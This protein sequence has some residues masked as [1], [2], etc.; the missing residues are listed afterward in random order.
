MNRST[1]CA[2]GALLLA[3]WAGV[4]QAAERPRTGLVLSGGGAR[5]AAHIGVLRVL[6]RERVPIDC[7]AGT[8]MGAIVGALY[9]SGYTPDE[10][11]RIVTSIDWADAFEDNPPRD[12]KSFRRKRDDDL[13]LIKGRPGIGDDGEIKF[14]TGLIQGQKISLLFEKL[15]LPVTTID[16][17]DRLPIPYRAVA[18]DIGT[19]NEVVLGH[20][21]LAQ[22]MRASMSIPGGFAAVEI[23]GKLLVD[24]GVANNL[25]VSVA[26]ELCADR[27]IAVDIST[28]LD[29]PESVRSIFSITNQL[30]G[31]LTRRNTEAQI[32]TL[33]ADDLLIV[34]DLGDITTS[35]FARADEAIPV[36]VT[37][38][39][40]VL[41]RLRE[42]GIDHARYAA[43]RQAH[44][45]TAGT[46]PTPVIDFVRIENASSLGEEV[47]RRYVNRYAG[48]VAGQPLDVAAL[49]REIGRL[50]GLEIF[51]TIR[52]EVVEEGG[53]SGLVINVKERSWGPNYLQA[54]FAISGDFNGE[55]LFNFGF[56]YTR[57]LLNELNGELRVLG[58]LGEDP[59]LGAELYQPLDP[60]QRWFTSA[61]LLG[62]SFNSNLFSGSDRL[63]EYRVRLWEGELAAG[64][65][66]GDWARLQASLYRASGAAD[67]RIGDG[68][69]FDDFDFELG[70]FRAEF[71]VDTLDDVNFPHRGAFG[72]LAWHGSNDALGADEE[73][74]QLLLNLAYPVTWQRNTLILSGTYLTTPDDDAPLAAQFQGG[75][76]LR[77]SGF[78]E[79]ELSGQHLGQLAAVLYRRV[80]DFNLLPV[81]LGMSLESGNVWQDEGDVFSDMLLAGSLFVGI[82]T[83][84]GP[85]YLAAGIAEGS[86]DSLY[87]SLGRPLFSRRR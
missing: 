79:N 53:R 47:I 73:Y 81:Y 15:T 35:D 60:G 45:A 58:Q 44:P 8:S 87:L 54:G 17:F 40:Q 19:G 28:P 46:A 68:A 64:R 33:R 23:D 43:H 22:A 63:A 36:G 27:V 72:Q 21:S 18:T 50:Y 5:G 7:I 34:P 51:E 57:T 70:E 2:L 75:G 83:P 30:I 67:L 31:F 29:E 41:S 82:D 11:E 71:S 32:A 77:L 20:G 55:S 84:V 9:A 37:A 39:E 6:E 38:A 65:N 26:R 1:L 52:Y 10:L 42:L 3:C 85:L 14:P 4:A 62:G 86:H 76:F 56:A 48:L 78:Q 66:L 25:P 12:E 16:D 13:Y 80:N 61:R 24:G 59:V 69:L 74:D 49:E